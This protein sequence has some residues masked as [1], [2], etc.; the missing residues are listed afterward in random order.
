MGQVSD[1]I[2]AHGAAATGVLGPAEHPGLE[3]SAIDDQLTAALEQIEQAYPALG[4]VEPVLLVYNLPRHPPAL[5]SQRITRSRESLFL[6]QELLAGS[7]PL[8]LRHDR[9][10]VHRVIR[11]PV[12]LVSLFVRRHFHFSLLS[13]FGAIA[14][15]AFFLRDTFTANAARPPVETAPATTNPM[16]AKQ[17]GHMVHLLD[18]QLGR[19]AA[20][21]RMTGRMRLFRQR[22]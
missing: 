21:K 18:C 4:S 12:F 6:H 22:K 16:V 19:Q 15:D 8:L 2:G 7:L 14:S 1:L 17:N 5:G 11:F 9:G 3:E 13:R 20:S 10:C